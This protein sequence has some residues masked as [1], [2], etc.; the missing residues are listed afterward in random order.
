MNTG[1]R[2]RILL[3]HPILDPGPAILA[4]AGEVVNYPQD[5]P[6]DEE[7]IRQV[8]EGCL[9]GWCVDRRGKSA[10]CTTSAH[11]W[12]SYLDSGPV[13]RTAPGIGGLSQRGCTSDRIAQP[14]Q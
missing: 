9:P 6:I 7:S 11:I 5:R 10:Y 2:P 13:L 3:M 1:A 8:V 4:E 12:I 14:R